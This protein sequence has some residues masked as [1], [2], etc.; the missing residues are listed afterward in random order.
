MPYLWVHFTSVLA[1]RHRCSYPLLV[2][3]SSAPGSSMHPAAPPL[4]VHPTPVLASPHGSHF[5]WMHHP[6]GASYLIPSTTLWVQVPL[7]CW[8][9]GCTTPWMQPT[10][11]A[12][13]PEC[14]L[15][16]SMDVPPFGCHRLCLPRLLSAGY[17]RAWMHHPL[18]ATDLAC[19]AP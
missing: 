15:S 10:L 19:T 13:A 9:P 6:L 3:A 16:T 11:F 5:S 12:P 14:R 4:W 1:P 2:A 7:L 18:G 17:L 8:Q